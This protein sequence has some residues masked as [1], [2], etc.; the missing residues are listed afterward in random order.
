VL[1]SR[2]EWVPDLVSALEEGSVGPGEISASDR[3]RLLKDSDPALRHR[4]RALWSDGPSAT[5]ATVLA[6]YQKATTLAGDASKGAVTFANTCSTCHVL[7][8]QGHNVGPNLDALADKTSADFLTAIVDPNA[9]VEP[10]FIAYNIETK[11]GRSLSGIVSAESAT[12]LT[13]AQSDGSQQKLLRS[14]IQEIRASGLSLM[15][16]GLEQNLA[17]TD[18]ADLIAYLKTSPRGFGS[19]GAE[20]AEAATKAFVAAGTNGLAKLLSAFDQLPYGSWLGSLPMPYCRQT[21]G[22]SRLAWQTVPVPMDLKADSVFPFRLPAAMGFFSQPAGKFELVLNGQ[23][24]LDF[25]VSLHDQ[26]WQSAD[27]KVR[28]SYTVMENNNEDSN[29]V[30]LIEVAATLLEP[31]KPLTF[32]VV[33][34]AAKSQRWFGVYLL[35]AP[36]IHAAR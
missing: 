34:S 11:D 12:T 31:G 14:D 1:L 26:A 23:R 19:A 6:R 28:M 36:G 32:E 20:R 17:V 25:N 8:G 2:E 5:R 33:G 9:A 7:R 18:L 15:P 16:E 10:R 24:A 35:P 13:L 29:G 3:Q 22:H 4:A 30:L 21:D 27:G